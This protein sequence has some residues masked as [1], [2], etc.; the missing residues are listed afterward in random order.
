MEA[1]IPDL[2]SKLD[3]HGRS[4]LHAECKIRMDDLEAELE[5]HRTK[6]RRLEQE[7]GLE[8]IKQNKCIAESP[9]KDKDGKLDIKA[10][11]ADKGKFREST[12]GKLNQRLIG[13]VA[14]D[15]MWVRKSTDADDEEDDDDDDDD[16]EEDDDTVFFEKA[17]IIEIQLTPGQQ[18]GS[19]SFR[20]IKT[21]KLSVEKWNKWYNASTESSLVLFPICLD[22]TMNEASSIA[23]YK[24][25]GEFQAK[26]YVFVTLDDEDDHDIVDI[27]HMAISDIPM[28]KD[29]V[30]L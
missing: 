10:V 8:Q 22:E 21:G 3:K 24:L 26:N 7:Q 14:G 25:L 12:V 15:Y 1:N 16:D 27:G 9:Y 4:K 30:R 19:I 29:G 28:T 5:K 2:V 20:D 6:I 11:M 23:A 17:R 18:G 13:T